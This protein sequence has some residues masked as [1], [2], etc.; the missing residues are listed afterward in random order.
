[1]AKKIKMAYCEDCGNEFPRKDL[2]LF[3]I[4]V[5]PVCECFY[6]EECADT[7]VDYYGRSGHDVIES[8]GK[9]IVS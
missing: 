3:K 2:I 6:C 8:P 5:E 4:N 9:V 1:M 7:Q